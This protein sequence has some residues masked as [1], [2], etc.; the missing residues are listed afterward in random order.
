MNDPDQPVLLENRGTLETIHSASPPSL[1]VGNPQMTQETFQWPNTTETTAVDEP[2]STSKSSGGDQQHVQM[3]T[4]SSSPVPEVLPT[5]LRSRAPKQ[6]NSG[7][8]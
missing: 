4:T 2:V 7:W 8:L 6:V 1:A 5:G 3:T